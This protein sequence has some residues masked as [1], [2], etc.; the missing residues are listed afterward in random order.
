MNHRL[1]SL[2]A[3]RLFLAT[4]ALALAAGGAVAQLRVPDSNAGT[5]LRL[6]GASGSSGGLGAPGASSGARGRAPVLPP[7]DAGPA[8][9]LTPESPLS[10]GAPLDPGPAAPRLGPAPSP[11]PA[12]PLRGRAAPQPQPQR[13]PGA[14]GQAEQAPGSPPA[15]ATIQL[16]D[17]VVAVVNS[18]VITLGELERRT[19]TAS[20][21]LRERGIELPPHDV[22]QRQML[23]RMIVDRAQVQQAREQ[24]MRV[25]EQQLDRAIAGIAQENGLTVAAMRDRVVRDGQSFQSFRENVRDEMLR[26]RLR[27]REV[28]SKVQVSEADIDAFLASQGHEPAAQATA[29]YRVAQI[30]LRVPEG[31]T[32]EQI[33][34]QRRRGEELRQQLAAGGNFAQLAASYSDAPDALSGGL[35]D[36][37]PADRLPELFAQA[38]ATM[39]P[40]EVSPLLRSPAGFHLLQLVDRRQASSAGTSAMTAPVTQTH[41]RHILIRPNDV[42]TEA[43]AIRRLS[44]IRQRIEAG[45]ADFAEMARQYS[46]DGSAGRGGDLGWVYPGDTVPEFERAMA[47]LKP[48]E[49]SEP[50]RTPFGVHLIQVL[51]RRTDEASPERA[52]QQAREALR[53]RRIDERYEDWL[54]QVRDSAYV[55][56]KLDA[57]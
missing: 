23:E 48:G 50:V 45:T 51:E 12:A 2:R 7:A 18:D 54:R 44:D 24:G 35:L 8:A 33:E 27:E 53:A 57:N 26:S 55:E 28:D 16:V 1:F 21:Q 11:D 37:R 30:L 13:A 10:P 43:E 56:Y 5:G 52:R 14:D 15:T 9:P 32:P 20:Q 47:A 34:S 19:E 29:E 6:P 42:I 22:L 4:G 36:W 49:I 25:D 3:A 46:V 38:V 31:A 39:T 17:R 40:G 41:A